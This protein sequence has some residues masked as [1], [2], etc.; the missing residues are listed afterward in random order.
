MVRITV[1][2]LLR[3]ALRP[4]ASV[5][6]CTARSFS[7]LPTLRPTLAPTPSAFRAPS[8]TL[9]SRGPILQQQSPSSGAEGVLDLISS[10]SISSNP[11]M[12]SM[13]VRCGPRPTMANASRLIQKRRHGF[14]SRI[15]TKNGRKTIA[16]RRAAGRRRLSA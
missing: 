16:R 1:S 13:Q 8:Q 11:A 5:P 4:T 6:R 12:Q 7:S 15:K 3:T 2:S 9:L 14:L 10:T